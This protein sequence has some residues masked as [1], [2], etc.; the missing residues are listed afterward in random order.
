EG[1]RLFLFRHV[2]AVD[3]GC[4][5]L[6]GGQVLDVAHLDPALR[7]EH[8]QAPG[9]GGGDHGAEVAARASPEAEQHR[10]GVVNAE[11]AREA[12]ALRRDSVYGPGEVE[13][14][15]P[16]VRAPPGHAA[17]GRLSAVVAPVLARETVDARPAEI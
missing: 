15:V 3:E 13:H 17:G 8:L 2:L 5:H 16:P 1:L 6:P 9:L 4:L 14:R 7:A 12:Q 10:G 11:I